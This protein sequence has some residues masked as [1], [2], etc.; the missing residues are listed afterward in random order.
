MRQGKVG[1]PFCSGNER[2][3]CLP[4]VFLGKQVC[5]SK[6]FC[7]VYGDECLLKTDSVLWNIPPLVV[8][9]GP[10][11]YVVVSGGVRS[12]NIN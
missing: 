7:S 3:F 1:E 11:G 9:Y 8:G 4:T 2:R 5:W 12:L 10:W 6:R